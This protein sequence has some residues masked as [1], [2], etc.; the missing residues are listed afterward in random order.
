MP[1]G[2]PKAQNPH[3]YDGE[4]LQVG[5]SRKMASRAV[6][7]RRGGT[8]RVKDADLT[9]THWD[10]KN[11]Q[12][13]VFAA[14]DRGV[15]RKDMPK[16]E[17][18]KAL[19]EQ[20]RLRRM[21]TK[22][23]N[24]EA[25]KMR[26]HLEATKKK[27][28]EER[29]R[30][31][32][33]KEDKRRDLEHQRMLGQKASFSEE[34]EEIDGNIG[35]D[36]I[37]DDDETDE[38]TVTSTATPSSLGPIFP[39][40][41][42]RI[43]E[44][45]Y[46]E[47]PPE[48]P[49][50]PPISASGRVRDDVLPESYL[51]KLPYVVMNVVT[52]K[53]SEKLEL[54]G[55]AIPAEVG[56]DFVPSLSEHIK[57]CARN[58]V[59][60]EPLRRAIIE[61]GTDW[62]ARTQVQWWNGRIYLH[63][64]PRKPETNLA[65]VYAKWR[66]KKNAK[67]QA[68]RQKGAG[69]TKAE[70]KKRAQQRLK[71]QGEKMLDVFAASE[72]R[73]PICYVPS[74]LDYPPRDDDDD[75]I[76]K[77]LSNLFYIRFQDTDLPHYYFWADLEEWEDPTTPNPAW[78]ETEVIH[79]ALDNRP[80]YA[81]MQQQL[82]LAQQQSRA[83]R[84]RSLI[85]QKHRQV[86]QKRKPVPY[87]FSATA[88]PPK[89]SKYKVALWAIEKDL[90]HHGWANT[91]YVLREKWLK[92]GKGREW[93]LLI[94]ELIREFPTGIL[95]TSPPVGQPPHNISSLAEK[96]A[97]IEVSSPQRPVEPI[98]G[99]EP[100]TRDDAAYWVIVD[101]PKQRVE[102]DIQN[103]GLGSTS[104][105]TESQVLHRRRSSV[106]TWMNGLKSPYSPLRTPN[107]IPPRLD[108]PSKR[109]A[110]REAWEERFMH[111][112]EQD[113]A[114]VS[115]IES[116]P[117]A[118]LK[119]HLYNFINERRRSSVYEVAGQCVFCSTS[120]DDLTY[121]EWRAHYETHAERANEL[122]PFCGMHWSGWASEMR[123]AH[124]FWHDPSGGVGES[125]TR[126]S[127]SSSSGFNALTAMPRTRSKGSGKEKE[128][129]VDSTPHRL[130]KVHFSPITVEKRIA[131]NDFIGEDTGIDT[132]ISSI[133]TMNPRRS[134]LRST[135]TPRQSTLRIDTQ[136]D[137]AQT[138]Q[139]NNRHPYTLVTAPEANYHNPLSSSSHISNPE[140]Y[141]PK[142]LGHS[143]DDH[144]N[145][146]WNPKRHNTSDLEHVTSPYLHRFAMYSSEHPDARWVPTRVDKS[147]SE[148]LE[149]HVLER[150]SSEGFVK[151]KGKQKAMDESDDA[152]S[153]EASTTEDEVEERPTKRRRTKI[154]TESLRVLTPA[155]DHLELDAPHQD[156]TVSNVSSASEPE[157][158][159][160]DDPSK[161]RGKKKAAVKSKAPRASESA[162]KKRKASTA[163]S[164]VP[165]RRSSD[166]VAF[167]NDRLFEDHTSDV[168]TGNPFAAPGR[169]S[170]VK[171]TKGRAKLAPKGKKLVS[172]ESYSSQRKGD[173]PK[174]KKIPVAVK[175]AFETKHNTAA[176][177][178][179]ARRAATA[180]KN[181]KN[182]KKTSILSRPNVK[183]LIIASAKSH[184]NSCNASSP[185]SSTNSIVD[186][187]DPPTSSSSVGISPKAPKKA[188][189]NPVITK[190]PSSSSRGPIPSHFPDSNRG[191]R[192]SAPTPSPSLIA[193]SARSPIDTSIPQRKVSYDVP[194]SDS[195]SVVPPN[196]PAIGLLGKS[197]DGSDIDEAGRDEVLDVGLLSD[198]IGRVKTTRGGLVRGVG[199][200]VGKR[201]KVGGERKGRKVLKKGK[202]KTEVERL[203]EGLGRE[204]GR[205][206]E[207]GSGN[208]AL[209]T[210]RGLKTAKTVAKEKELRQRTMTKSD[211]KLAT[212]KTA[213]KGRKVGAKTM[214]MCAEDAVKTGR[215]L[216]KR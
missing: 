51:K 39:A 191:R 72:Y 91:M 181:D 47:A 56:A 139:F 169:R 53:T 165:D 214:H 23:A 151:G 195:R 196:T 157:R 37:L 6:P 8:H 171:T 114:L 62:A 94:S 93:K 50:L 172:Q 147:S 82:M 80:I 128:K 59:L 166:Y 146:A 102:G 189:P 105:P 44:W 111:H 137:L 210:E 108:T 38:S 155:D 22:R 174:A 1:K 202:R 167:A 177:E 43:F 112:V 176:T 14:R 52:T 204:E 3:L 81:L 178:L 9:G 158:P 197:K 67:S 208:D 126:K 74:P 142:Y 145:G 179:K 120:L 129:V 198:R 92:E 164:K 211:V 66:K 182:K 31:L 135:K 133:T 97:A 110:E 173:D 100:W 109:K 200:V 201:G 123:A 46:R 209:V 4:D 161:Q 5:H 64:P 144:P 203:M 12:E 199:G 138:T 42:L 132:D 13:L 152:D 75:E 40:L 162:S 69:I 121:D 190:T 115:T 185:T 27:E 104:T 65:S 180:I 58:G 188:K 107:Q 193:S 15:W 26:K 11:H 170:K 150:R 130:S 19:A 21:A 131:Y 215:V 33:E 140:L 73:P 118:V 149:A 20:D 63:L 87:K 90:Y 143:P 168:L 127:S 212:Q 163:L 159:S 141:L 79:P 148:N 194:F 10:E 78:L 71:E 156:S 134:S 122:C 184:S 187:L 124:I 113:T 96:F 154:T 98:Y 55:R 205:R 153:N 213:K 30:L 206:V 18:A 175:T 16:R 136:S 28:K 95:P 183:P 77:S 70:S 32:Q 101:V 49:P 34:E 84:Y 89:G 85:P 83:P 186:F 192:S 35:V 99:D 103:E 216:R 76:E 48:N 88:S 160:W 57:D 25:Y 86:K 36:Q 60:L 125:V 61:R 119:H 41:K 45:H 24:Q 2:K 54:P 116:M 207:D 106:S 117:V 29:E 7:H 17:M 68:G